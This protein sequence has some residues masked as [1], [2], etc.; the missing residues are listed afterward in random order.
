MTANDDLMD[1]AITLALILDQLAQNSF[2]I[3]MRRLTKLSDDLAMLVVRVNPTAVT[4]DANRRARLVSLI[5]QANQMIADAYKGISA[6]VAL[7]LDEV[8]ELT[9]DSLS[10]LVAAL[11][12]IKGLSRRLDGEAL[13]DARRDTLITGASVDDWWQR[14]S[15]DMQ[16]RTSRALEDALRLTQVGKEPG[17]GDLV[18]AIKDTGP[19]SL[20]TAAPR[21]A[22]A[23]IRGAH[24]AIANRIRFETAIRHPEL[25]RA[26]QHLSI[27][28][29][30]TTDICVK[31]AG[32]LWALDG[33]AIGGHRLVFIRPPVHWGCRS[34]MVLVL[35]AFKDLSPRIQRRVDPE[36]FDGKEAAEPDLKIWL[37]QRSRQRDQ[38]PIDY[39]SARTQLGL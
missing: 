19:G 1:E 6:Q 11:L 33:T 27:L 39:S 28:D 34:H 17:T 18:D 5:E 30:R 9:Q 8:A 26:F 29:S 32:K 15:I 35:H 3:V 36:T 22:E 23:L 7:D 20:F 12:L 21:N 10:E 4:R 37:E 14:Q 31:R 2:G 13:A 25:F 38:G 24:H 16:F